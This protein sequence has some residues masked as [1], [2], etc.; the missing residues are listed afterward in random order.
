MSAIH[1]DVLQLG[2]S[3]GSW[4]AAALIDTGVHPVPTPGATA[5][6]TVIAAAVAD[7]PA[8][9]VARVARRGSSAAAFAAANGGTI[10][11]ITSTDAD[12]ATQIAGINDE[13]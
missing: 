7:W 1:I 13:H 11:N 12:S 3:S 6:S 10:A 5:T 9:H 2:T 4:L 8:A